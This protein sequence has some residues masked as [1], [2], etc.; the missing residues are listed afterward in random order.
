MEFTAAQIAAF[1]GGTVEGNPEAKVCNVAKIE[2]G[3]PG[4][5]SFLA[6]P[7]YNHYLY[8]T[9]SSI[10]LINNDF[11]L[12]GEV[13]ATLVRV[14]DAYAAFAKLLELYAQFTQSKCGISSLA[15][16]S[17]DAV[18]GEDTYIGEFSYIGNRAKIG[19][20]VKIYPQV[21]IGDDAVI[22]DDT[23]IY[24]GVKLYDR[25][26]VGKSC[27]IHSGCV[28]GADG[29]G[30]APQEDG[31]YK[32]I[33][34]VGN[35]EIEDNVEIGANTTIDRATMGST[36]IRHGVK[37]DNLIQIAHNVEIGANTGAAAQTGIS[38]STKVG[39]RCIIAGQVGMVGHITIADGTIIGAQAGVSNSVKESGRTLFGTPAINLGE[40]KRMFVYMKQLE[41]LN[42][43]V[44]E[45][46]KKLKE[47][48]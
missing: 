38:G 11:Q 6:N 20:R 12:Q 34:Q 22:G 32:K 28:C 48:Q 9:R 46:E 19:K 31:S 44:D 23:T 27:I 4:M 15:F 30:F 3:A 13:S 5:L 8:E 36:R 10:V 33:P 17:Q 26:V 7:K 16:V 42:K 18:I 39:E 2:E 40:F 43:R 35:V 37:L 25:T 24:A 1:L 41:K 47:Q 21:Y 45:L 29:F 14:P